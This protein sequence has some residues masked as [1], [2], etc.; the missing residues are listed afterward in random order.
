MTPAVVTHLVS[1]VHAPCH[2][3]TE[4]KVDEGWVGALEPGIPS[5]KLRA[6][7]WKRKAS[8]QHKDVVGSRDMVGRHCAQHV[9]EAEWKSGGLPVTMLPA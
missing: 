4:A 2:R 3:Q 8:A 1:V 7:A 6:W 5:N 9:A